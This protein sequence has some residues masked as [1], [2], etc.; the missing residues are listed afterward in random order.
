M[1]NAIASRGRSAS[2]IT[3]AFGQKENVKQL[4]T[5]SCRTWVRPPCPHGQQKRGNIPDDS[6]LGIFLGFEQDSTKNIKWYDQATT[7]V[8]SAS[9]FAFDE[10]FHDLPSTKLCPNVVQLERSQLGTPA[11]DFDK[12]LAWSNLSSLEFFNFPFYNTFTK[13]LQV[14][15]SNHSSSSPNCLGLVFSTDKLN[16]R[17]FV[18]S[19]LKDSVASKI[20]ST[21]KATNNKIKGQYTLAI[22]ESPVFTQ[23]EAISKLVNLHEEAAD[24][25]T[26]TF[27]KQE[28]L[29]RAEE[30]RASIESDLSAPSF[31]IPNPD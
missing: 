28:A 27:G 19:I 31:T 11:P 25:F 23:E 20:C 24:S 21:F 26:I 12:D 4:A 2:P 14:S 13:T 3:L 5:F 10:F 15:T 17:V 7:Q 22:N 9:N 18:T 30:Q 16:N 6:K 29:N 8:K 1:K